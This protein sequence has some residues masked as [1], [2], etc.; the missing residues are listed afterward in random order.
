M[1]QNIYDNPDFFDE[2]SRMDRSRLGLDGAAEWTSL[3]SMLPDLT[4]AAVLDMGC[5][6]GW[7]SRWAREQGAR[8]ILALDVSEKML[9]RAVGMT[10]DDAISYRRV[11]LEDIRLPEAAFDLAFSSLALH[12]VENL[13]RIFE[14]VHRSLVPGGSFVFSIE[15]P[16]YT[17]PRHPEWR[18]MEDGSRTWPVDQYLAEGVRV[19]D[20]LAKGVVKQHR[21]IGTTLNSLIRS[22]FVLTHVNEWGPNDDQI[23][24]HPEWAEHRD[25]PMFLLV[26]AR[27]EQAHPGDSAIA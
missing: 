6:F 24:A 26:S 22:G 7:F 27:K 21:T 9:R 17:A 11:N 13:D 18:V 5:G 14:A 3:R 12:Y 16:V 8:S 1:T 15:H 2:Y 23:A 25:R 19:T 20:W 4:G 10:T